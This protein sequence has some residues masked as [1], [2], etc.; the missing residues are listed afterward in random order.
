MTQRTALVTG[1]G[2]AT[3]IG[4]HTAR[5]L[6]EQGYLVALTGQSERVLER[7]GEL[8]ERGFPAHGLA[9]DLTR[10]DDMHRLAQW[11]SHLCP[12]LDVLVINHGMTSVAEPMDTTG[13]SGSIDDTPVESFRA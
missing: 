13:E 12:T 7:V 9:A 3:G 10:S 5:I 2:S 1:A 11:V 8:S 6:A 4:F